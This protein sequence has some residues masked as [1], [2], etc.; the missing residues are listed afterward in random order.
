MT[1]LP[2]ERLIHQLP[3]AVAVYEGP[4]LRF[5]AVSAAYQ[6][7]VGGRHLLG[8]PFR[9]AMHEL[10]GGEDFFSRLEEVYR[11][12]QP[13][14][15]TDTPARWDSDGDGIAEERV[16]DFVY[17]PV[18]NE[19]GAVVG[20]T[21]L[22]TDVT[23]RARDRAELLESESRFR[24][25]ADH[26]PVMLWVTGADGRCEFLN[27]AWCEFTGQTPATGLGFGWLDAVHPG[28]RQ[29]A[30]DTFV[31]AN[32]TRSSF[33]LDYRL[34]RVD[35][36][37]RW[38]VDAASPRLGPGGEFLG[39]IGTVADIH[40]RAE[41]QQELMQAVADL[42]AVLEVVPV[43]IG[44]ARD[45][46]C[47][48]IRA[49]P[50]FAAL[51]GVDTSANASL[52]AATAPALP[53]RVFDLDGREVDAR[54]LPMQRAARENRHTG[55]VEVDVVHADGRRVR[56][57][58]SAA[59]LHDATGAVRGAVGA[60]VDISERAA[61]LQAERA[62]REAAEVAN[63]AKAEFLGTM[64]HEL[65][66]PLNA[67]LGYVELLTLGLRGEVTAEQAADLARVRQ[68]AQHLL[69][70]ISDILQYARL[71]AGQL[72]VQ[73]EPVAVATIVGEV[74]ALLQPQLDERAIACTIAPHDSSLAVLGDRDR[75]RQVLLN[76]VS[77]AG[78]FTAIGGRIDIAVAPVADGIAIAVADTG[79]GIPAD[80]LQSVFE[81][82]V[83][84]NRSLNRPTDGVG[85]GLAISTDL[86]RVMGGRIDLQSEV[87]VGSRFTLVLPA[88]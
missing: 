16:I 83:Q 74:V 68:S 25:M 78:K 75:V 50:A 57:M 52:S 62:A 43:G 54:D 69:G 72:V 51:L 33:R 7:I 22:I 17:S 11:T 77:N 64:S 27:R 39:Y 34:R 76:L 37:Y 85:L 5:R 26:A 29:R 67:I 58:E 4:E 70:L 80:K 53:F 15:G 46:A 81:P 66:Q 35:G 73:R 48:D 2:L 82:F 36:D 10:H 32:A 87:G 55:T 28:D 14:A 44:I 6:A 38:A 42:Q 63:A 18:V 41:L 12:G 84:V 88:A 45:A 23:E 19:V 49:N 40:E 79:I 71:E 8:R 86:A 21:A 3:A 31:A 61:L 56:L 20:V 30:A 65:R 24:N 9:E 13:F 1:A 59:P 47:R 60:F